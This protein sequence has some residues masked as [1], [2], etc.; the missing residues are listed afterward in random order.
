MTIGII[1]AKSGNLTSLEN[2]LQ[3]SD[4]NVKRLTEPNFDG[5]NSL[6]LPGQGRFGF[7]MSKL[8]E[9]G[10]V[11]AIKAWINAG[12]PLVG[13][14]V[15]MQILFSASEED[16]EAEGLAIFPEKVEQLTGPKRPLMGW[17]H[18]KWEKDWFKSGSAYFVNSYG[19]KSS[20]YSLA[21]IPYGEGFIAAVQRQN[22]TG[23]QFHPEKSGTWGKELLKKCLL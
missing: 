14:C 1:D 3:R 20:S 23:F 16:P 17:V 21:S 13:I 15:G 19:V 4:L 9:G 2:T 18:V 12:K 7:V 22:V 10:F 8:V 5:I 6:I 11:P